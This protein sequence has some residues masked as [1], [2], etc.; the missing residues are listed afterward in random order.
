MS[1]AMRQMPGQP[2]RA[3]VASGEAVSDLASDEAC[4][5]PPE[6]PHTGSA[7]QR[8][9][10]GGLLEA[11]LARQNLQAAWKRVKANKGAAGVDGLDIEQTAQLLRQS[12]PDIRQALLAGSYR[13]SPVRKVLIPKPDGSQRELGIP[14]VIDRLIQQALLQVLQPL[15]DPT[16][17]EHSHGFRPGRRAHD[18]VK[19]ARAYVQSGKR[20]VVDVDLAKFFDRVNHDI[21]IDRL[22]KRIDDAGVIRLIR[23][24]LNAGIM[25]GGVVVVDRHMGTP[26]G[27]PLSPLLANVLLDEVDK[28]L[29]A[30]SYCFARYADDCNVYVGSRRA[31]ERVMAY[32]RKLYTG[33]KLQINEAKSAVTSAFGRKFLGYGLWVAKGKEVKCAVA[34]KAL[35]N[36]KAR[37]RQLTRRS[38]GRSMAQVVE[39][40]R[41]YLLGW[42]AYFGM[43]QTPG[44]WR[45]LDEWLR[46][47]LRA[48]QL[49]HW[50]RPKAIYR[51]LKVLGASEDV[52]NQVAG[53]CHRWWR[54]SDGAIKRVLTIAYFDR[55]GVPRLS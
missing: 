16:F 44:V 13:P 37:I 25:D 4:G 49:R 21:L 22:K 35:D 11:A 1:K 6:H 52:A 5:P 23:A 55:L 43:A 17:S 18:A 14:T 42:K 19:A 26:Q 8:A 12:W 40:L 32:L 45:E 30:R 20:V 9:G 54:N 29:E 33:L 31:G 10:T 27:G 41:P 53:N 46:H 50:K 34:Y 39:K 3:S 2:G 38:G 28:A 47:R 48:I 36:F 7:K 24:Y 15:I 51:E